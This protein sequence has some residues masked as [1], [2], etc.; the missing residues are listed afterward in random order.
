M[1]NTRNEAQVQAEL[2]R[3]RLRIA[4]LEADREAVV[5]FSKVETRFRSIC[6][7]MNEGLC[8]HEVIYD[9]KGQARD[10]RILDVNP[11]YESFTQLSKEGAIGALAS[12]LYKSDE[13]P[14][15]DIYAKV[16]DGGEPTSFET[17]FPPMEKHFSI[18]VFSPEKGQFGTIFFDI[19]RIKNTE[20]RFREMQKEAEFYIDLM[21]HDLTNFNHTLLG[22][23]NLIEGLMPGDSQERGFIEKCIRQV[24]KS[25]S[26]I[27]KV[28]SFSRNKRM[29]EYPLRPVE[30][31]KLIGNS[32]TLVKGLYPDQAERL[33]FESEGLKIAQGADLMDS[34]FTNVIENAV[35]H[36]RDSQSPISIAVLEVEEASEKYWEVRVEDDGSGVPDDMKTGIFDRYARIG[37]ERGTGLGLSLTR[38][39]LE[40]VG[41]DIWVENRIPSDHKKGCIFKIRL[42]KGE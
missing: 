20:E 25:E 32:I 9:E 2:D 11:A 29:A 17:Y 27:T 26:L 15:L 22:Y 23:L 14:Y 16:A 24:M 5:S 38:M 40:K 35:K 6:S 30:L 7:A 39:I 4:Q 13:P 31:N 8:L 12:E 36:T 37:Q 33:R 41:G 42:R 21:S 3:L 28:K 19:T 18:S 34:V 10:Y 1:D